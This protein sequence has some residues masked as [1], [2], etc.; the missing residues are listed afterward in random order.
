ML[1]ASSSEI[2]RSEL[3]LQLGGGLAGG[4]AQVA[5]L[6]GP[7]GLVAQL[8]CLAWRGM[9]WLAGGLAVWFDWR[10]GWCAPWLAGSRPRWQ[11]TDETQGKGVKRLKG[12]KRP[13]GGGNFG[14]PGEG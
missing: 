7:V 10:P 11:E 8:G 4:A 2:P 5:W 13:M 3:G 14:P 6:A 12:L 9:A 1:A